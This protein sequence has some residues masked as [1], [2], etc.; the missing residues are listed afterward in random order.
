[1]VYTKRM[2]LGDQ[3]VDVEFDYSPEEPQAHDDPGCAAYCD[4][5]SIVTIHAACKGTVEIPLDIICAE[6]MAHLKESIIE[7]MAAEEADAKQL[8]RLPFLR[9]SAFMGLGQ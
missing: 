1:M 5:L 4:I 9:Q 6:K 3:E 8:R 7:L 2:T